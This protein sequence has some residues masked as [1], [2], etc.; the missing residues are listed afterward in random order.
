VRSSGEMVALAE[1]RSLTYIIAGTVFH[2]H[3]EPDNC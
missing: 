3:L 2:Y 1:E